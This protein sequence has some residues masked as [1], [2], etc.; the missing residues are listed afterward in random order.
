MRRDR[1]G[2]VRTI[3]SIVAWAVLVGAPGPSLGQSAQPSPPDNPLRRHREELARGAPARPSFAGAVVSVEGGQVRTSLS[4]SDLEARGVRDGDRIDV[5]VGERT[6]PARILTADGYSRLRGD[7]EA[8]ATVDVDVVS[9]PGP[10]EAL[11]L[12]GL[13]GDLASFLGAYPGM[14]V[15]LRLP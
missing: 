12:L 14:Q 3:G 5:V 6:L 11:V 8:L 13:S 1:R 15:V 4:W 2:A 10:D 9:V 7:R